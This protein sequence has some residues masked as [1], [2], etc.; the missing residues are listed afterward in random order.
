MLFE[1][2]GEAGRGVAYGT[3]DNHHLLNVRAGLMGAF[4]DDPGHFHKW[5]EAHPHAAREAE[6]SGF[7]AGSF[8][9]RLLYGAYLQDVL[10]EARERYGGIDVVR[11]N[12]T[13]IAP[14]DGA[15][16]LAGGSTVL[17]RARQVVLAL[18][19][20]PP[21]D[22]AHGGNGA[23]PY[24]PEV[25][26][27]LCE[28]GDVFLIGTGLTSLDL[29]ATMA[30]GKASGNIHIVSRSG[31]FPQVHGPVQ[32][33]PPYLDPGHLPASALGLLTRVRREIRQAASRGIGWQSVVDALRPLNQTIWQA[34]APAQKRKFLRRIRPYWDT[35]R[36]R[37]A[38]AVM[39][40]RDRLE[41]EG[42]LIRH[43]GNLLSLA[44]T[45]DGAAVT[46][47]LADGAAAKTMAVHC[48]VSCTGP[49]SDLRKLD[50]TL[51]RNLLKRDLLVPDF[52]CLGA[53]A[54]AD[55]IAAQWQWRNASG[56]LYHRDM[57]QGH[58]LRV[59]GRTRIARP[60]SRS[61]G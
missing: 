51:V 40:A 46:W 4:A 19:N 9:P 3:T 23:N 48:A 11:A 59:R 1:R 7:Q 42:R 39:A 47:Q 45:A 36:H 21:G 60:G 57:A 26:A 20:F 8:V 55:G 58:A 53:D 12:V 28:P 52:L 18:G 14:L 17:A 35:H 49:Q 22:A 27:R 2:G 6:A 25:Y 24:S 10:R 56:P 41:R 44:G 61:G 16:Q 13:D 37:C 38:P 5:L 30:Q 31:L 54:A 34:L 32:P 43:E 15:Y 29:L 50:D 33:Y